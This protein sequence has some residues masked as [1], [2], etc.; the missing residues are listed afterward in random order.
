MPYPFELLIQSLAIACNLAQVALN[1]HELLT[2]PVLGILHNVF[3][4]SH[5]P[6]KLEGKGVARQ[7]HLQ[8]EHRSYVLDIEHHCAVHDSR[9]SGSIELEVGIV[10]GDDPVSAPFV[11]FAEDGLGDCSAGSR[12]RT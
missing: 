11:Q 1:P 6:G 12:F 7:S 10:S 3:R 2:C 5:L 8:P 9:V 4:Q